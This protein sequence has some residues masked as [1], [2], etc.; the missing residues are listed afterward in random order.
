R[1]PTGHALDQHLAELLALARHYDRVRRGKQ[2]RKLLVLIPPGEEHVLNAQTSSDL[3]RMLALPFARMAPHEHQG[4]RGAEPL[5]RL[6]ERR[7]QTVQALDGGE[8]AN[9]QQDRAAAQLG[10]LRGLV[11]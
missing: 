9:V 1:Q 6:P 4:R 8:A 3:R 5:L 2:V 10:Y 11:A 7:N